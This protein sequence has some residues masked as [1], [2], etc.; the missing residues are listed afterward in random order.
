MIMFYLD[1]IDKSSEDNK[2]DNDEF[3]SYTQGY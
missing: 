1:I 2:N 3:I